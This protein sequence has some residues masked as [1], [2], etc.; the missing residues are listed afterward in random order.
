MMILKPEQS[1]NTR[2]VNEQ[3][4]RDANEQSDSDL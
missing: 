1:M 3:E 2:A 4:G